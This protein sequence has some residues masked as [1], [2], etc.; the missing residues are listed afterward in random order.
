MDRRKVGDLVTARSLDTVTIH[1]PFR[2]VKRGGRKEIHLPNGISVQSNTDSVLV[3]A[4]ARAFRWKRLIEDGEFSTIAELAEH[5]GIAPSYMTR[6]MRLT[7]L[8]PG[9]VEAI[10]E[11]FTGPELTLRRLLEPFPVDWTRQEDLFR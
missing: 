10:L 11:G 2:V 1:I 5:E 8:S 4:L 6:V 7:L 9:S 3:K